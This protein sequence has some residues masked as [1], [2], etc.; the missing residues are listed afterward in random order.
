MTVKDFSYG[1]VPYLVKDG[2]I[3]YLVVKHAEGG[4]WA[5]PKGHPESGE[6]PIT[7]AKRELREETG[8]E[9]V[10]LNESVSMQEKYVFE[11]GGVT[12]DKTVEFFV[13]EVKDESA[14]VQKEEITDYAWLGYN[15]ARERL[16]YEG[17]K[18]ILDQANDYL[19][20]KA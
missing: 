10:E 13:G 7:T 15:A 6:N 3:E 5:F 8:I 2:E 12:I 1:V 20:V 16:T 11:K 4:H 9:N 19:V 18:E 14:K 17:G